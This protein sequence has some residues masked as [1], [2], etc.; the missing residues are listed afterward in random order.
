M[1]QELL[2]DHQVADQVSICCKCVGCCSLPLDCLLFP[3]MHCMKADCW[4]E[5]R[6]YQYDLAI[7]L[8]G[9]YQTL[10]GALW[11][12]TILYQYNKNYINAHQ[13]KQIVNRNFDDFDIK[14]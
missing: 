6:H 5:S 10:I 3:I 13:I 1:E 12:S 4:S 9:I 14:Y 11:S 8:M 7:Q 2:A